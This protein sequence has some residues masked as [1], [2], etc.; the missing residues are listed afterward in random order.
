VSSIAISLALNCNSN[1]PFPI[2][3]RC[4]VAGPSLADRRFLS[5]VTAGMG[6]TCGYIATVEAEIGTGNSKTGIKWLDLQICRAAVTKFPIAQ[7]A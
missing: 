4:G 1:S 5:R 7:S 6:Y 2:S 3:N